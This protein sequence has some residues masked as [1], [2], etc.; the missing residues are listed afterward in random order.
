MN[1]VETFLACLVLLVLPVVASAGTS[2][3]GTLACT[4]GSAQPDAVAQ[5][6]PPARKSAPAKKVLE[7]KS[8][9]SD[10]KSSAAKSNS[11]GAMAVSQEKCSW[12]LP[13]QIGGNT[14]QNAENTINSNI[15]GNQ[16]KDTG[17][18]TSH[19]A[20]ADQFI[21]SLSGVTLWD[22]NG[23]ARS[24]QGV[25]T[26]TSATGMLKGITGSGTYS[27]LAR[28][29]GGM[30]YDV[31]GDYEVPTSPAASPSPAINS[32]PKTESPS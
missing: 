4:E 27:G 3:Y 21:L 25:W 5:K 6:D 31:E 29:Q 10:G 17:S 15:A 2:F 23:M 12:T 30:S 8:A 26:F 9:T 28:A 1:R 20:G 11:S 24:R 19:T 22:A 13:L 16:S 7:T 14:I 32:S 18:L